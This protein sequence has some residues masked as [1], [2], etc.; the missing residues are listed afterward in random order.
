LVRNEI[1]H[2]EFDIRFNRIKSAHDIHLNVEDKDSYVNSAQRFWIKSRVAVAKTNSKVRYDIRK[3]NVIDKKLEITNVRENWI[4]VALPEDYDI[5]KIVPVAGRIGCSDREL[6]VGMVQSNDWVE[7]FKDPYWCPSFLWER[8]IADENGVGLKIGKK[9]DFEILSVY[10]DYYRLPID[11]FSP[12]LQESEYNSPMKVL[13]RSNIHFELDRMQME[14]I[15]DIAV[16]F[17]CRDTGDDADTQ[18][19]WQ[20][21]QN[22]LNM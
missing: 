6:T 16:Y 4:L 13:G 14:E 20:K 22:M 18:S 9:P 2:N 8:T 19:Q 11:I 5:L 15:V 3:L 7:T 10:L 21:I 17:A 1:I 12:E